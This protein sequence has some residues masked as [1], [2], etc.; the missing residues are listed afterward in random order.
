MGI[1]N[2]NK[3]AILLR[4]MADLNSPTTPIVPHKTEKPLL[5]TVNYD[6]CF[7]CCTPEE[8]GI[9]SSLVCDF[10]NKLKKNSLLNMHSIIMSRN[11]KI[12]CEATFGTHRLDLHKAT[13]S[14]C[15]SIVSLA[16][17]IAIDNRLVSND[18]RIIDIFPELT[19]P[20][21]RLKFS[22]LTVW[23]LL[24][25]QSGASFN[26]IECLSSEEWIKEFFNSVTLK[27]VG[28]TFNYN[29]LNTYVLSA[30]VCKVS[31][32]SLT[33]YLKAR[34]FDPLCIDEYFWEKSPEN[35]GA[36][37]LKLLGGVGKQSNLSCSFDS[38]G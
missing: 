8:V 38:S 35:I 3:T 24:T 13:F 36:F 23:H 33:N 31:G 6:T 32:E 29:S 27:A 20:I 16:M 14:M 1:S 19:N 34:L 4:R 7:P 26:E 15:K 37:A 17:G 28:K 12:F 25:M 18:T 9:N 22:S 5:N 2:F 10:L 11:G 21:I 30:I